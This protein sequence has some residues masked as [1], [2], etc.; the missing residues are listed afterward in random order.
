MSETDENEPDQPVSMT[1]QPAPGGGRA[2]RAP[3]V[4]VPNLALPR[5]IQAVFAAMGLI[6]VGSLVRIYAIH[7]GHTAQLNAYVQYA[8]SKAKK[9]K[10][11]YTTADMINDVHG[12]RVGVVVNGVLISVLVLGLIWGLRNARSAWASRWM[13]VIALVLTQSFLYVLPA[14]HLIGLANVGGV[15]VGV[16]SIVTI[17]GLF[18]P[19]S[20]KYISECHLSTMTPERRAAA[21]NRPKMFGPRPAGQSGGLFG[22]GARGAAARG[23]AARGPAPRG[24][25]ARQP[26]ER[27]ASPAAGKSKAKA[28]SDAEAVARGAELARSRAR[29]SKSRRTDV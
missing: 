17:I 14:K 18:V 27:P 16:G 11:P 13:L 21:A 12:L 15:L 10:K 3:R 7:S 20:A 26:V 6:V 22:G 19:Q 1:K 25:A 24:V 4:A 2:P 29:A 9:P 5:S 23:A 28:R 8:N